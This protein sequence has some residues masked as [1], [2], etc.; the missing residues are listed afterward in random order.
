VFNA[1]R[2][3]P[4]SIDKIFVAKL[5]IISD[6]AKIIGRIFQGEGTVSDFS[7]RG[8]G[9]SGRNFRE[10]F[11]QRGFKEFQGEISGRFF[12]GDFFRE[13]QRAPCYLSLLSA[14]S[15]NSLCPLPENSLSPLLIL[16]EN[17]LNP[18]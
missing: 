14:L 4:D 5:A 13:F 11:F 6:N 16:S 9:V 18:L 17:S 10:I 2:L 7:G 3:F 8:Q 12:Q 1:I 15:L